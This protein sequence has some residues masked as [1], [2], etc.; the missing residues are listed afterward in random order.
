MQLKPKRIKPN[1]KNQ[2]EFVYRVEIKNTTSVFFSVE[3][4]KKKRINEIYHQFK[5]IDLQS[6]I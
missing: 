5:K 2:V 1:I 4:K 6:A 3:K